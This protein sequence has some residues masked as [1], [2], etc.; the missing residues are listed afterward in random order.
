MDEHLEDRRDRRSV[1]RRVGTYMPVMLI[2]GL[3]L[4]ILVFVMMMQVNGWKT[5][6]LGFN[7]MVGVVAPASTKLILYA[8]PSS[9]LYFS[10][11]GGDYDNLLNPWRLYFKDRGLNVTELKD[12]AELN[13][14]SEGV[15]I[16][17]SALSL[18]DQE[19]EAI[20]GFRAKGG[21]VLATWATGT[22]TGSGDWAG[23]QF[24]ESMGAKSAGEIPPDSESRQLTLTGE[25]PLTFQQPAGARIWMG[26]TTESLL[27]LTGESVAA[28]FMN[29]PRVPEGDRLNE[30]AIVYSDAGSSAGRAV[31]FAFAETS[32][33]SRPFMAHQVFDDTLKWL[34][35]QPSVV[36]A[37]WPNGKTS[38]QVMEMD[39]EQSFQNASAFAAMMK[40]IGY[41][42]TFYLLTSVAVQ[43][44]EVT[45]ALAR[46]FEVGYHG[47]IHVSFKD[48][49][50]YTQEQRILNMKA[51]LA[52]VLSD[53]STVTGFRAPTE[54]YDAATELLLHKHGIRHH[55]ADPSR[56][57]GRV[58]TLVKMQGVPV[59]DA[60][61]VLART[62]RDDINLYWEKLD[63]IQ[64]TKALV[65]DFDLAAD[66]GA[67]GFL[68]IHSQNFDEGSVLRQAMPA[69]LTHLQTRRNQVWLASSGQVAQWW[70]D[71]ER[72]T[73]S[74]SIAGKRLDFNVTVKG[75]Q[76]VNG[77]TFVIM[78]PQ[79]GLLPSVRSTKIGQVVPRVVMLDDYRAVL[80]F[81]SLKPG[82][83]VFQASFSV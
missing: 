6:M 12:P 51:E 83:Y 35:R 28:R 78:L 30:G 79:K 43:F 59:E 10:K 70:R 13:K 61:I 8:S 68:S 22:R 42:S 76:P 45:K 72:I 11:I 2:L 69:F 15:L 52:S 4:P 65:D 33:E 9:R 49:P 74:S 73:I 23:W 29:W 67:L 27:R 14:Q 66:T 40:S 16:V 32:W 44:P 19:R 54:G 64:T 82:D 57:E 62:Q 80:I 50:I 63:V 17:P 60:L 47:D 37:A 34:Q 38:A 5:P 81:E 71:R 26:K 48:Q 3:A 41:R 39:T 25:S 55:A 46:D 1:F 7:A 75:T 56:L 77:A 18:S 20:S 58:P 24:L 36:R 21:G 53:T 31:V